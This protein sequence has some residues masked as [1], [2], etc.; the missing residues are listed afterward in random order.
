MK[1]LSAAGA[2]LYG[3]L[4]AYYR[5]RP[6]PPGVNGASRTYRVPADHIALF[7]DT[8]WFEGDE[9]HAV[10]EIADEVARVV[11]AAQRFVLM[12]VFLFNLHHTAGKSLIPTTRQLAEAFAES[13]ASGFFITD[14]LNTT[15]GTEHN[16]AFDWLE[17][18]GV[19]ICLTDL[20][21][22]RDPNLIYTPFWRLFLQWLGT[23]RG[24]LIKDPLEEGKRTTLRALLHAA[25]LK[26]NHR[27]VVVADAGKE[28]EYVSVITSSNFE[29]ASSFFSNV[30]VTI[31]STGV[32]RHFLEAEKGVARMSGCEVPFAITEAADEQQGEAAVTPLM[33]AQ[34]KPTLLRDMKAA[35]PD[36]RLYVFNFFLSERDAIEALV[37]ADRRGV[38]VTLVLDPNKISFGEK[39]HGLPNQVVAAEFARRSDIEVRWANAHDEE[40]HTKF[41]LIEKP[42]RC[43]VHVGS[44]NLDRLSLSNTN[45]EN[46]VRLD[47]PPEAP[48]SRQ[49]RDYARRV[50]RE[51]VSRVSRGGDASRLKYWTYRFQEAT[52]AATF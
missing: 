28:N 31:R 29:N 17:Q 32:A 42:L 15:Y 30:A 27:K 2:A 24:R 51:P 11:R 18:A 20:H 4:S 48:V 19:K 39:K 5:F 41:M 50:S 10:R 38:D 44:A 8:V 52:G 9:R 45:L 14:P 47:L 43:V 3:G 22:L 13:G 46:N 35:G 21:R 1:R 16:E 25:T 49:A 26:A 34:I 33:G 12:D 23:G 40:F 36:D 37:Q 6:Q 7:H